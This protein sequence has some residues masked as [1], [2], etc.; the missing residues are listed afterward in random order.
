MILLIT[1][2]PRTWNAAQLSDADLE[3]A[4]VEEGVVYDDS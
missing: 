3:T 1:S 4:A 2:D